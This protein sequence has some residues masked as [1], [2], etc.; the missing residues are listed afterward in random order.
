M[1]FDYNFEQ[2]SWRSLKFKLKKLKNNDFQGTSVMN[3][4]DIKVK[5]T[6]IHEFKHLHPEKKINLG[7]IIMREYPETNNLD[8]Y[9]P[10][11]TEDDMILFNKYSKL[12]KLEKN[13]I[14]G[15]RLAG[16]KYLD[17]H[18]VIASALALFKN[19]E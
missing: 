4:S 18:Q 2:L 10:I 5:Y 3:Y 17:M 11:R 15:G 16:Y 12:T 1:Y 13:V 7:T 8:P 6:R 14:F 9:Y 19:I